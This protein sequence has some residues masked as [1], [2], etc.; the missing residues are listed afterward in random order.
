MVH[1]SS[2][3]NLAELENQKLLWK[4]QENFSLGTDSMRNSP[5]SSDHPKPSQVRPAWNGIDVQTSKWLHTTCQVLLPQFPIYHQCSGQRIWA[6]FC[7][8]Q[9]KLSQ[10][11][12]FF[13]FIF[14]LSLIFLYS[15]VIISPLFCS[16]TISPSHSST[17]P[18]R[19]S[20]PLLHLTTPPHSLG[21]QVSQGSGAS[22]VIEA[23]PGSLVLYMCLGPL[24]N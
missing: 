10:V 14:L 9:W 20:P 1:Y 22:S 13:F 21:A 3:L 5:L 12:I 17:V 11:D 6:E 18:K 4:C 7:P 8:F 2:I 16:P 23:R 24:I 15:P 19:M